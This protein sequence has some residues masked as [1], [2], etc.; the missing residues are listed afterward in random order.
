VNE[1]VG[2]GRASGERVGEAKDVSGEKVGER[3]SVSGER[4]GE[5]Q[6]VKVEKGWARGRA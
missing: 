4:V 1:N 3:K 2:E 5:G 6:G